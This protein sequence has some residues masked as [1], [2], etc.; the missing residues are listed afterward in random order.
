MHTG[1]PM[2]L[3][4]RDFAAKTPSAVRVSDWISGCVD[5]EIDLYPSVAANTGGDRHRPFTEDA[6][7][8]SLATRMTVFFMRFSPAQ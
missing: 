8:T 3:W 6:C 7:S 4:H 2:R 5:R 1:T